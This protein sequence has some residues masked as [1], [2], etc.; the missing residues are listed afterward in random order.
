MVYYIVWQLN[1]ARLKKIIF[2]NCCLGLSKAYSKLKV[3]NQ[4][5]L[6]L[7]RMLDYFIVKNGPKFQRRG[8]TWL[9][10]GYFSS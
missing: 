7:Y 5:T 8:E 9:I 1:N 3:R 6:Y 2:K 10:G 4:Y